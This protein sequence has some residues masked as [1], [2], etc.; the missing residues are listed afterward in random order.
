MFID[1]K[2]IQSIMRDD[3]KWYFIGGG[4]ANLKLEYF[5]KHG[6]QLLESLYWHSQFECLLIQTQ[7]KI[8]LKGGTKRYFISSESTNIISDKLL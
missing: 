5:E 7:I 3:T 6:I 8:F 4:S 1:N 2:T